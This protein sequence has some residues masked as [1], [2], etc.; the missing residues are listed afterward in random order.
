MIR[1]SFAIAAWITAM[2]SSSLAN[3]RDGYNISDFGAL[4]DGTTVNTEAINN[5]IVACAADGGGRVT[6]PAGTFKSGTI[7]LLSNVELHLEMGAVLLASTDR[8]DFPRQPQPTYR[9]LKDKGGWFA[10]VYAVEAENIA[11]TGLGTGT[12][13]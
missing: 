4:N 12:G 8:R 1:K 13:I 7:R 9:S 11:V 3:Q 5:A 6:I 2:M 10:L